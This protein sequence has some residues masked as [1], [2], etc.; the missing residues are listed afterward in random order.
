MPPRSGDRLD[1]T[2]LSC[3][4]LKL[5]VSWT[6]RDLLRMTLI[7]LI[8]FCIH[9]KSHLPVQENLSALGVFLYRATG[10]F[11]ALTFAGI[12]SGY[13]NRG[14]VRVPGRVRNLCLLGWEQ[15]A[16]FNRKLVNPPT[17][18]DLA[19]NSVYFFFLMWFEATY[20]QPNRNMIEGPSRT[21]FCFVWT[22]EGLSS[23]RILGC[24]VKL[25]TR[26]KG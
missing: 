15:R 2:D 6:S 26:Q 3:Y 24:M 14:H 11:I 16:S 13:L 22:M 1:C 17:D 9:N 23:Q 10:V 21:I 20:F 25:G 12:K 4:D 8:L 19:S 18:V 7:R 5:T